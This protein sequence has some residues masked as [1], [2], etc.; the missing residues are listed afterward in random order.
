M[1]I[2]QTDNRPKGVLQILDRIHLD[3][4]ASILQKHC[5]L[6]GFEEIKKSS[7]FPINFVHH[8]CQGC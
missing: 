6:C 7:N 5:F 3:S 1:D 2:M 8:Y 4:L